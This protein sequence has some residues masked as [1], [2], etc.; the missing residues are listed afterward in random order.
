MDVQPVGWEHHEDEVGVQLLLLL[1]WG[2]VVVVY[3]HTC[4][5]DSVSLEGRRKHT[6]KGNHSKKKKKEKCRKR[7]AL[8]ESCKGA[9]FKC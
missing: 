1:F 8:A 4:G 2:R 6:E 7:P 5:S 9:R 3:I